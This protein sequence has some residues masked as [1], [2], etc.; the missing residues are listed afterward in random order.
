MLFDFIDYISYSDS[1]VWNQVTARSHFTK[2]SSKSCDGSFRETAQIQTV[3]HGTTRG[4]QCAK[5]YIFQLESK[6]Q[7]QFKAD[8]QNK[9]NKTE[10]KPEMFGQ[11]ITGSGKAFKSCWIDQGAQ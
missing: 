3:F 1:E 7:K 9:V 4:Q 11:T 5:C 8:Y 6:F 10:S 2:T